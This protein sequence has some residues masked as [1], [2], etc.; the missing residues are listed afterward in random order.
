MKIV[1]SIKAAGA[2]MKNGNMADVEALMN[3]LE[4]QGMLL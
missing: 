1:E 2:G 3:N 4:S